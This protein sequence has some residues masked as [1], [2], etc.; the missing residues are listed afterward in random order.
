MLHYLHFY[1]LLGGEMVD[2]VFLQQFSHVLV[3][4]ILTLVC[5]KFHRRSHVREHLKL[6]LDAGAI[7]LSNSPWCNAVVLV[8]KKGW[9]L[10]ILH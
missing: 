7:R 1:V 6:M 3:I 8:H 2:S 9:P 10:E 5:L 4:E